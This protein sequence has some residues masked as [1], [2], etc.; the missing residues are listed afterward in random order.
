MYFTQHDS[1]V[2]PPFSREFVRQIN[3]IK[4]FYRRSSILV[5]TRND[6]REEVFLISI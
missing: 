4:F 6:L 5:F 2:N 3:S 1:S